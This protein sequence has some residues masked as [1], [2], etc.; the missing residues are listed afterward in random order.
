MMIRNNKR[1]RVSYLRNLSDVI[2][3]DEL[4]CLIL[5]I[6]Q[7]SK[8]VMISRSMITRYILF[9]NEKAAYDKIDE[10][11]KNGLIRIDDDDYCHIADITIEKNINDIFDEKYVLRKMISNIITKLKMEM[12]PCLDCN[13]CDDLLGGYL[14]DITG[15]LYRNHKEKFTNFDYYHVMGVYEIENKYHAFSKCLESQPDNLVFSDYCQYVR[16]ENKKDYL[17]TLLNMLELREKIPGKPNIAFIQIEIIRLWV[18][19]KTDCKK[20]ITMIQEMLQTKDECYH[21]TSKKYELLA[22]AYHKLS[23]HKKAF[24]AY[25]TALKFHNE[26][27]ILKILFYYSKKLNMPEIKQQ[28]Y[29][30][31]IL[32]LDITD[33]KMY[34]LNSDEVALIWNLLPKTKITRLFLIGLENVQIPPKCDLLKGNKILKSLVL[35]GNNPLITLEMLKHTIESNFSLRNID[36]G[37]RF[38]QQRKIDECMKVNALENEENLFGRFIPPEVQKLIFKHVKKIILEEKKEEELSTD[39]ESEML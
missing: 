23:L 32:H 10:L 11:K 2:E 22:R 24:D 39:S 27:E 8:C 12:K 37:I 14:S 30:K 28:E 26:C 4:G 34:N 13:I 25:E 9:T 16:V 36:L 6:I 35:I 21:L 5:F 3:K 31:R 38:E 19:R 17:P 18:N 20:A 1:Q 15:I 33:L 29:L 7:L